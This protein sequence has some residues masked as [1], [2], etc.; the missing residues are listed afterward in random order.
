MKF[1]LLPLFII[2]SL[3]ASNWNSFTYYPEMESFYHPVSTDCQEAQEAFDEGLFS[4]YAFNST[5]AYESFQ[6]AASLDPHLAMAYWG[7]ALSMKK[8]PQKKQEAKALVENAKSLWEK[9]SENEKDYISAL[10]YKYNQ[11]SKAY[12]EAMQNLA[13]KYP[14]DPDA[15]TLYAESMMDIMHWS[16]WTYDKKPK[17][18]TE[19]VL[20]NLQ[21][22]LEGDPQHPGA[23]HFFIHAIE[24]SKY[25]QKGLVSADR[26]YLRYP[27]WGH[28]LHTPTHIYLR[29]GEYE[30]SIICNLKGI[31]ADKEFI[32]KHGVDNHYIYRF[33]LHNVGFL[34]RCYLWSEQYKKALDAAFQVQEF[35]QKLP[36]KIPD[37]PEDLLL[38]LQTYLYFHKWNEIIESKEPE[39]D[40]V[41]VFW[42]FAKAEAYLGLNQ[43][44]KAASEQKLFLE[45]KKEGDE[46]CE[47]AAIELDAFFEKAKGNLDKSIELFKEAVDKLD[48]MFF[49]KWHYQE[50]Q[51]LGKVLLQAGRPDEAEK[52][53]R[54][55]LMNIQRNGRSLFGLNESLKAQNKFNY[56]TEREVKEALKNCKSFTLNDL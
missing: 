1:L 5:A 6:K 25:P 32:K 35:S 38:V 47:L 42:H 40:F 10:W 20:Q 30:K 46:I 3:F 13:Q 19:E 36:N 34:S 53:F 7:M 41:K 21:M 28:L 44:E 39:I 24:G 51:L 37:D 17:E 18:F 4:L 55:A 27:N 14:D 43:L 12:V 22:A 8:D 26:L 9:A 48:H 52:V 23:N 31:E 16:P 49:M 11:D 56:W 45:S 54:E 33:Y 15:R 50:R 29:V 2:S